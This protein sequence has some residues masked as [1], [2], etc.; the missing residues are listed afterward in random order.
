MI[1]LGLSFMDLPL[2]LL[3]GKRDFFP[4]FDPRLSALTPSLL[5]ASQRTCPSPLPSPPF[6]AAAPILPFFHVRA[7]PA[8]PSPFSQLLSEMMP[9]PLFST[10]SADK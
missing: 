6:D 5:H 1:V 2:F 8:G 9:S 4:F 3:F 10:L 7:L